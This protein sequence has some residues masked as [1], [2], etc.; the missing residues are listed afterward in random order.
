MDICW[1]IIICKVRGSF[2][3]G[4]DEKWD[5]DLFFKEF[6]F[7]GRQRVFYG[8]LRL[9]EVGFVLEVEVKLREGLLE[10]MVYDGLVRDKG[11]QKRW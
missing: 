1:V 7:N 10:E 3:E 6:I 4:K 5:M 8:S 9:N 11:F 2:R